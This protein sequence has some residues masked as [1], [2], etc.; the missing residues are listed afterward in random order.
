MNSELHL[1]II[2]ERGRYRQQDIIDDLKTN[3]TILDCFE[4]EWSKDFV[5]NNFT[6]FYGVN[7]PNRSF[8]EKEC[9]RGKFLLLLLKDSNPTYLERKTS[10]GVEIVNSKM[11]DSKTLYRSWTGG[12]HKIHATNSPE[13]TNH[14]LTLLLGVN[15]D[16]YLK[17]A[18]DC[19]DGVVKP[20]KRDLTGFN[21]WKSL[22]ELFYT[23]NNTISYVVLRN[24]EYLPDKFKSENHGDIDLLVKDFKNAKYILNAKMVFRK[25]YRVHCETTIQNSQVRFD[26]RFVGDDYYCK[27]WEEHIL[28]NRVLER[29]CFFIPNNDDYKYSLLYHALIHKRFLSEEYNLKINK[30]FGTVDFNYLSTFLGDNNYHFCRPKDKSVYYNE[31][32]VKL[33]LALKFIQNNSSLD[34]II[35]FALGAKETGSNNTKFIGYLN[36][37]K[38]FIKYSEN[39]DSCQNEYVFTKNV[40][41]LNGSYFLRPI[42]FHSDGTH[43]F[44]VLEYVDGV[45][46]V[47][48][49][50]TASNQEKESVKKQMIEI[51]T[52]LHKADIMHRDIRPDNFIVVDNH[53]KLI[54]FQYAINTKIRKELKSVK[55]NTFVSSWLGDKWRYRWYGWKDSFSFTKMLNEFGFEIN[56]GDIQDDKIFYVSFTIKYI[57]FKIKNR[58]KL[59]KRK[60]FSK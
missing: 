16:D 26:L 12:G 3:F 50:T 11:F 4:I 5:A 10:H 44:L 45:S 20:L 54:D 53:I 58:L 32:N 9:G 39:E 40:S 8:K 46:L 37:E 51:C 22:E 23:L 38:V 27:S 57:L 43:N 59:V 21:G 15:Y 28:T 2:W 36:G 35:P 6:R 55:N 17:T 13:E 29:N 24:F 1:M 7:L 49:L 25:S 19:W 33:P 30:L 47:D 41:S 34:N 42:L 31:H 56:H 18:P 48:Y 60:L 52:I 14:D